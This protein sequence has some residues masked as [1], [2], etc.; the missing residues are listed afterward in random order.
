M[1]AFP[2]CAV[3]IRTSP[4]GREHAKGVSVL[5][6]ETEVRLSSW[7]AIQSPCS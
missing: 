7:D 2:G 5:N 1:P 6:E 3:E 4:R